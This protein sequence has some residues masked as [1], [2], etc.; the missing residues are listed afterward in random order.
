MLP[1]YAL[2]HDVSIVVM[3]SPSVY[4]EIG[5]EDSTNSIE[6]V[7]GRN[8]NVGVRMVPE[9]LR[10][11]ET[12][13]RLESW[14]KFLRPISYYKMEDLTQMLSRL[15]VAAPPDGKKADIYQLILSTIETVVK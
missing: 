12:S 13:I 9:E 11:R 15:N 8:G 14:D 1:A 7:V 10:V 5:A 4:L 3:F 6:L 2:Y